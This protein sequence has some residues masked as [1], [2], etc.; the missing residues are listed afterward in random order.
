LAVTSAAP[1]VSVS[2]VNLTYGT[3]L[4]NGQLSS[5]SATW[6]VGGLTVIVAG[7]FSY[8]TPG[9]V[10]GSGQRPG[11]VGHVHAERYDRL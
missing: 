6:T 7:T 2:P 8:T 1:N 11:R 10:L 5:G 9:L 4:A 3:A